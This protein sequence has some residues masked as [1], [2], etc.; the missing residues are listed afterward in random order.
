M[1]WTVLKALNEV[2][3][4]G[5]TARR[6]SFI[7]DSDIQFLLE[8]TGELK[9]GIGRINEGIDFKKLYEKKHLHNFN[10]YVEFLNNNG[11]LTPQIRFQESDI[12]ILMELKN[13]MDSGDLIPVRDSII[14]AEETVRGVSQMFF[15]NEKY[16]EKSESLLSA[17]K[18]ILNIDSLANDKDQQYKYVLQCDNPTK[19]VLCENLDFLKRPSKPRKHHIELWYAG[20]KNVAKL[21][22]SGEIKFPIYYSCDWDYDGLQIFQMVKKII[23]QIRLLYPNGIRKSIVETEHK[24]F[25]KTNENQISGL[26]IM[27]YN[28]LEISLIKDLISNDS[29]IMEETNDLVE[30][31]KEKEKQF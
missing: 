23:P 10:K 3:N 31:V 12:K 11:L 14:E 21:N 25:W 5:F 27:N 28:E 4:K 26:E 1:N 7:N 20:G 30:M 13:G 9:E 17:V 29:W 19:I 22:F 6:A 16:L 15:K 18:T 8:Q 24:S 2:Y